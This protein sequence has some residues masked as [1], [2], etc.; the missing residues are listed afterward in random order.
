M[1]RLA[2]AFYIPAEVAALWSGEALIHAML[3]FE[4]ALAHAEARADV[5]P[6]EAAEAISTACT[7]GDFN[8]AALL[9]ESASAGTPVIPLVRMLTAQ[10]A[11]AGRG[12]VHWGATSQD[13]LD[14]AHVL[15]I[16]ESLD[17]LA[18][19]LYALASACARHAEAHRDTLMSGRT[20]M[21]QALPLTFGLKAARWLALVTRQALRVQ[22]LRAQSAVLQFGGAAGTLAALRE[23]GIAVTD[24]LAAE[25]QLAA[26][27]LPWHAER[28][29][30][31]E[32]VGGLGIVAGAMAKI[33]TDVIL[34]AQT[35]VG[36]AREAAAPGKGGSSAMPQKRNPVDAIEARAAARLALGLVPLLLAGM[37]QEHERAAGA[38][39][40]EWAALPDLLGYTSGAVE[41][42]RACI[43]GLQVDVARMRKNLDA[44]GGLALSESL[45]MAL[46]PSVGKNEAQRLVKSLLQQMPTDTTPLLAAALADSQLRAVLSAEQI[47]AA[48]DPAAYLGSTQTYIDRALADFA[49]LDAM[50][51]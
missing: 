13:V 28:D 4:A 35:E 10:V 48:L 24:L 32:V 47:T 29:R 9:R 6:T 21:Q 43:A 50:L 33:A 41:H 39:H 7:H 5:I 8:T 11:E 3:R 18:R 44:T 15:L 20:L 38:W 46:A 19:S 14:T 42:T 27:A 22:T 45:M 37:E 26:P 40:T 17:W 25:L 36:E 31:A 30:I 49:A 2:D 23:K 12:Y 34:L 16:G 51:A 1:T